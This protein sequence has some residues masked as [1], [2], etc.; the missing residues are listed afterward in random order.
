MSEQM[1]NREMTRA[2][3]LKWAK[4]RAE[5]YLNQGEWREA[6]LSMASD[7]LKHSELKKHSAIELMTMM[8]MGGLIDSVKSARDFIMGFN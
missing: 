3:H 1:S 5:E 6:C 7:L 4:T 8:L 2:E